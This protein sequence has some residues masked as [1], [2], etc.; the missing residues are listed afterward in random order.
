[1]FDSTSLMFLA[2]EGAPPAGGGFGDMS[3][4]ILMMLVVIVIM[5]F[6][7]RSRKR[8][9][10]EHLAKVKQLE[11]GSRVMLTSGL[12]AAVEK[13]DEEAQE[14]RLVIDE[15]KKVYATYALAA[16]AKIF[17]ETKQSSAK[18]ED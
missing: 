2:Q 1:M 16:V 14:V 15:D 18:K 9:E 7:S 4:F 6:M 13:V 12:I 5:F 10:A 17:E 3:I 8:Q 11:K